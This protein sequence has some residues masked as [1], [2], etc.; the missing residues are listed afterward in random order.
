MIVILATIMTGCGSC[1][2]M[3]D[4]ANYESIT[5]EDGSLV[6]YSGGKIMA[7]FSNIT[8]TYSA[9]DSDALYFTDVKGSDVWLPNTNGELVKVEGRGENWYNS[10]GVL[11]KL[12]D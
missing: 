7:K 1:E 2:K 9:A 4:K 8:I 10:P 12:E 3:Y 6:I 5:N 11:L